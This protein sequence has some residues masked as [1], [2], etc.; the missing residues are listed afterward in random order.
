MTS[1]NHLY[2]TLLLSGGDWDQSSKSA[3][4]FFFLDTVHDCTAGSSSPSTIWNMDPHFLKLLK[5]SI[6]FFL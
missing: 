1:F 2:S 4:Y 5:G 6:H 3:A